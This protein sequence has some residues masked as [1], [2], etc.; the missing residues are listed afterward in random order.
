MDENELRELVTEIKEFCES[1]QIQ[2]KEVISYIVRDDRLEN[3]LTGYIQGLDYILHVIKEHEE[4]S[5]VDHS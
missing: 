2:C 4:N 5:Y 3:Y 1:K